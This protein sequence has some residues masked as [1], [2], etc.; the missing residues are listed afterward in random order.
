MSWLK[1][2]VID[3]AVTALIVLLAVQGWHWAEVVLWI[4]TPLMVFVKGAAL[5]AGALV[6]TVKND[7]PA[8]FFHVLYGVNVAVL[9]LGGRWILGGLWLLIWGLSVL[10]EQRAR[11]VS[12]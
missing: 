3:L 2:V 11:I 7:V 10:V 6:Q 4:Y 9:M 8:W 1:D 12:V 5:L